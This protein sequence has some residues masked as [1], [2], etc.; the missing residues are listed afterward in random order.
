L[1]F[2][3]D[4]FVCAV[5]PQRTA[6]GRPASDAIRSAPPRCGAARGPR[7]RCRL[8]SEAA[9]AA[10]WVCRCYSLAR[11]T[12][13]PAARH[14]GCSLVSRARQAAV[15]RAT[16]FAALRR[17]SRAAA[18]VPACL[19]SRRGSPFGVPLLFAGS[20]DRLASGAAAKQSST[21]GSHQSAVRPLTRSAGGAPA[22]SSW[23]M[24]PGGV[25]QSSNRVFS[26]T[27]RDDRSPW[28]CVR[29]DAGK[30]RAGSPG[31]CL[32]DARAVG[33]GPL[34]TAASDRRVAI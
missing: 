33:G 25:R 26:G 1:A 10:P 29:A 12:G 18:Q 31:L 21:A 14:T 22:S 34:W 24:V 17:R 8:P 15:R 16:L 13:S 7:R 9:A 20:P 19:R 27:A 28:A 32:R 30:S 6:G 23:H 5:R 11:L 2:I 4:L 3:P